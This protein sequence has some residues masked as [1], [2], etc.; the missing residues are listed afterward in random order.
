MNVKGLEQSIGSLMSLGM[1]VGI[2]GLIVCLFGVL[3]LAL[4]LEKMG[5]VIVYLGG[6]TVF[7]GMIIHIYRMIEKFISSK[8]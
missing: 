3:L 4:G 5:I 6:A 1:R 8:R 2:I 7:I